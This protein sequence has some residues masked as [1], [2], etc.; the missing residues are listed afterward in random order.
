MKLSVCI[1]THD[2]WKEAFG[3]SYGFLIAE[4]ASNPPGGILENLDLITRKSSLLP[5]QRHNLAQAALDAGST[6]ILW[7]DTDMVFPRTTLNR[8]YAHDKDIVG[9]NYSRKYPPFIHTAQG[10]DNKPCITRES[11]TGLEPVMHVGMGVCLMKTEVFRKVPMPWFPMGWEPNMKQYFGED[12][13]FFNRCRE[14]GYQP[15]VDHDLSKEV[16]H[17]GD[18]VYTTDLYSDIEADKDEAKAWK[19]AAE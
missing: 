8:L 3:T 16:G 5:A 19:E 15:Y 14:A 13:F 7:L 18:F 17:C 1:P 4:L 11:S 12:I 6:H 9:C 10:M 2:S